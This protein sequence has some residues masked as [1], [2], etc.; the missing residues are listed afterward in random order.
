MF[1]ELPRVKKKETSIH[2]S[3][4]ISQIVLVKTRKMVEYGIHMSCV[5]NSVTEKHVMFGLFYDLIH[6][7]SI[8]YVMLLG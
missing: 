6:F 1:V 3:T 7:S 2:I 8:N 4:T 5:P